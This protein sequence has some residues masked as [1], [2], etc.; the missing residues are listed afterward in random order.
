MF[1]SARPMHAEASYRRIYGDSVIC[2]GRVCV[3]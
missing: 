2:V 3:R 1:T